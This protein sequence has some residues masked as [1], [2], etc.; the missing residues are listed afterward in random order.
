MANGRHGADTE[1]VTGHVE[2]PDTEAESAAIQL[3]QTVEQTVLGQANSHAAAT[4]TVAV[5]TSFCLTYFV[6]RAMNNLLIAPIWSV[7]SRLRHFICL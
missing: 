6:F 4:H 1:D 2:V 5:V 3:Q 7:Q